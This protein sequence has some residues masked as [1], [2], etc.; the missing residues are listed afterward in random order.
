LQDTDNLAWKLQLVMAGLAPDSLLDTYNQERVYGADENILNSSRSTDFI[1]PKSD[2]SRIFRDAVLDLA[3]VYPFARP[4]VNSGRLSVPCTYDGSTLNGP[5]AVE[6]PVNLRPGSTALDAPLKA[7][8]LLERLG[9]K[10]QLL[11]IGVDIP[12]GLEDGG[13]AIESL[14]IDASESPEFARRYLGG[15]RQAVYLMRPD[16]HVAA[17]WT[18]FDKDAVIAA[19]RTATGRG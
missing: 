4:L 19:L 16:Q 5:D 17:R 18:S 13:I 14:R 2:T 1:T 12:D 11:A 3:E 9:D 7:S 10:F 15:A 8:W 6:L